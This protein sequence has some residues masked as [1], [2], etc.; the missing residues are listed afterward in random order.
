MSSSSTELLYFYK[1]T[2]YVLI[3]YVYYKGK[4]RMCKQKTPALGSGPAEQG[5]N[6]P[7]DCF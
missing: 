3:I 5:K 4:S 2:L 7:V 6:S 1:D